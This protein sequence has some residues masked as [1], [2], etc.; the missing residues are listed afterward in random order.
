MPK[1]DINKGLLKA[2]VDL[3]NELNPED[4]WTST[5]LTKILK[6]RGQWKPGTAKTPERTVHMYLTENPEI[7]SPTIEAQYFLNEAYR[8]PPP[9]KSK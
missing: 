8:K 3:I 9:A 6:Q 2:I 5:Y 4:C 7:F 1:G